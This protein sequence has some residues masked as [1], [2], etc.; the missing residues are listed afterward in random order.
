MRKN[1]TNKPSNKLANGNKRRNASGELQA[2]VYKHLFKKD[3]LN[4][5]QTLPPGRRPQSSAPPS[6]RPPRERRASTQAS[7]TGRKRSA[8]KEILGKAI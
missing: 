4:G 6:P 8:Q 3:T 2:S 7:A 5:Q 1:V